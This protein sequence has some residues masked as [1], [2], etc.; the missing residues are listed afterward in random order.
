MTRYI[1][2]RH[3]TMRVNKFG[4]ISAKAND[5]NL[6][7]DFNLL[8][9]AFLLAGL[10]FP[11]LNAKKQKLKWY[12]KVFEA[13]VHLCA[14]SIIFVNMFFWQRR[15]RSVTLHFSTSLTI[16]LAISVRFV[17]C[18]VRRKIPYMAR[19]LVL[20]Y[21]DIMGNK[22]HK[23]L[24]NKIMLG[25]CVPVLLTIIASV[26]DFYHIQAERAK[27]E[28]SILFVIKSNGKG[29]QAWMYYMLLVLVPIK[30]YYAY[31]VS[32]T[33]FIPCVVVYTV[34]K[35]VV[36]ALDEQ[37]RSHDD[38]RFIVT[39]RS[40][41]VYL[42]FYNRL[43]RT[44]AEIDDVISPCV[45][46]LYGLMVSG[47]F[48]TLTVLISKDTEPTSLTT[49]LHNVIVFLLTSGAFLLITLTASQVTEIAE[50]IKRSLYNL[51]DNITN[52]G[53]IAISEKDV[54]NSYLILIAILNGSQ[55]TF[56]GWKMFNI[57]R[58][59]ILTTMGV[60]ISYGVIIIQ[61]GHKND[62]T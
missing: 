19:N 9:K 45:L 7:E 15:Y 10:V 11:P 37:I 43:S 62:S 21:D 50:N 8:F 18:L 3:R 14:I 4:S 2:S 57:N 27:D 52:N 38:S 53:E 46:L 20:L 34:A 60:M 59:F 51:A 40:I 54:T 22:P 6:S 35:R 26:L 28:H 16:F 36:L 1:H 33:I 44:I 39:N 55:L 12:A 58:S 25:F 61:I 29:C 30:M 41:N 49:V 42:S 32:V 31:G 17:L 24:R 23:S 47:Q 5:P 48:Y 13:A 56:T